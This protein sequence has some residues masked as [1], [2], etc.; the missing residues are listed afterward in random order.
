MSESRGEPKSYDLYSPPWLD[1]DTMTMHHD[2]PAYLDSLRLS[3]RY[4][5]HHCPWCNHCI[6][7]DAET[8]KGCWGGCDT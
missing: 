2:D 5:C 1:D 4:G 8:A 7:A 3:T 6:C